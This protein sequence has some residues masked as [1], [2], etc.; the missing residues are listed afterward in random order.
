VKPTVGLVAL[1]ALGALA[2]AAWLLRGPEHDGTAS[3]ADVRKASPAEGP[4]PA[5]AAK[6]R[7]PEA[8]RDPAPATL[9]AVAEDFGRGGEGGDQ[10]T[11]LHRTSKG[12]GG[13]GGGGRISPAVGDEATQGAPPRAPGTSTPG[14]APSP[15]KSTAA[16]EP[17]AGVTVRVLDWRGAPVAGARVFASLVRRAGETGATNDANAPTQARATTDEV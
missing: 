9:P 5:L 13:G 2:A 14:N 3:V 7:T 8:A 4:A 12:G 17:A 10:A 15:T 16:A 11:G 6:D 1:A